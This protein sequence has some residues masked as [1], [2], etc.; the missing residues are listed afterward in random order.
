[1]TQLRDSAMALTSASSANMRLRAESAPC[2]SSR[3]GPHMI[4]RA[5]LTPA[6]RLL[7][8]FLVFDRVAQ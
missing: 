2:E 1:M 5:P 3:L 7:T 4:G 6:N 8:L